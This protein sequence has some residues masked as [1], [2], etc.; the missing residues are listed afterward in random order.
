MT[1]FAT[2]YG[3]RLIKGA[4][5]GNVMITMHY[6]NHI[7]YAPQ[8]SNFTSITFR[9]LVVGFKCFQID[10][11]KFRIIIEVIPLA[12]PFRFPQIVS[13]LPMHSLENDLANI[14]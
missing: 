2:N 5:N 11:K 3:T 14:C 6:F 12:T 7:R 8:I 1:P 10:A 4:K 13:I 9:N